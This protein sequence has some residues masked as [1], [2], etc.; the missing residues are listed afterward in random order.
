MT[1]EYLKKAPLT[2]KSDASDTNKIVQTILDEIEAGGDEKALEYA[3]KFDK[4]DGPVLLS[5]Q[6]SRRHRR[7]F[8]NG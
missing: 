3:A 5:E 6:I 7:R 4:Y 2:S 1:I 8:L